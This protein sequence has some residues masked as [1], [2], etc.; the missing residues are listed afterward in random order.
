M[1]S[2]HKEIGCTIVFV[3]HNMNEAMKLGERICIMNSGKIV[4]CDTPYNIQHHP[5]NE[6]VRDFFVKKDALNLDLYTVKEMVEL[7]AINTYFSE[8]NKYIL[9]NDSRANLEKYPE[10]KDILNQ[11]SGLITSEEMS[12]MNFEVNVEGK[13]PAEVAHQFL[14]AYHLIK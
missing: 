3:T 10:L 2:I 1:K 7:N 8:Q 4:Q 5:V 13:P 11:L 12:A 9:Y 14:V 6:F